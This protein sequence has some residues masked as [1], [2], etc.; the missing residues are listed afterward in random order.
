MVKFVVVTIKKK[1]G[2][3]VVNGR[4]EEPS[5]VLHWEHQESEINDYLMRGY[6]IVHTHDLE[7]LRGVYILFVLQKNGS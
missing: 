2:T 7:D 5:D 1:F 4:L 6:E 3:Q